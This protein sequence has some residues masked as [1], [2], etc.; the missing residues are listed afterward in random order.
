MQ[1]IRSAVINP[2]SFDAKL[3]GTNCESEVDKLE[4]VN[5][6]TDAEADKPM[7]VV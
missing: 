2:S 6:S 3:G 5:G 7:A 4:S 1:V